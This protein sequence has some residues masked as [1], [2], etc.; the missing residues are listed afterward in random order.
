MGSKTLNVKNLPDLFILYQIPLFVLC[1]FP[2]IKLKGRYIPIV[3]GGRIVINYW[4]IQ[5]KGMLLS[6]EQ[7]L[8]GSEVGRTRLRRRLKNTFPLL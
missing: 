8:V 7:P 5:E 6:C 1:G 2:T 3:L 4:S